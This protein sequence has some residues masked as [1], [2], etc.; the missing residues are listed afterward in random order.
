MQASEIRRL[1][2]AEPFEPFS[3]RMLDRTTYAV[4]GPLMAVVT[5]RVVFLFPTRE[6]PGDIVDD[7]AVLSLVGIASLDPAAAA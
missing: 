5:R 3:I 1:L 4:R 6:K 2:D 7:G